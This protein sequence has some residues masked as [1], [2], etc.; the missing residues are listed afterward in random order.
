MEILL[1]IACFALVGQALYIR[2]LAAR[3]NGQRAIADAM[4]DRADDYEQRYIDTLRTLGDVRH[5]L[6]TR[7]EI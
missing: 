4:Q 6:E 1:A 7:G 5:E 3:L 2:K